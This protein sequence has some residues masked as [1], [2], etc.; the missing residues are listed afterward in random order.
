MTKI[1]V[2]VAIVTGARGGI[3]GAVAA[4]LIKS[5]I[6]VVAVDLVAPSESARPHESQD[7]AIDAGTATSL[8]S[9]L[10]IDL[11]SP[12]AATTVLD[13]TIEKL[14]RVDFLVSCAGGAITDQ[15][16]SLSLVTDHNDEETLFAANYSSAVAM[17]QVVANFMRQERRGAIVTISSGSGGG[18]VAPDGSLAHYLASK[19]ALTSFT[20]SLAG[21]LGPY[22]VRVNAIAPGIVLSP[23][24]AALAESRGIGTEQQRREIPM[25]RFGT[26]DDVADV[27]EF[28]LS[29]KAR[30]VT[31]Q[32]IAVN[33]GAGLCPC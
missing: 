9:D 26:P 18:R 27:A 12:Q 17:C 7:S 30:Y 33:G 19:A 10:T 4:V 8:S 16:H 2:P 22:N 14:G 25:R 24:V 23:R 11:S 28:L 13:N 29:D 1:D 20:R 5:G 21:E 3:G 32:C 31:G 6:H 15:A